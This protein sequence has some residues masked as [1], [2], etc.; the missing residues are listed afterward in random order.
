M[1]TEYGRGRGTYGD[2]GRYTFQAALYN[3]E[4][5]DQKLSNYALTWIFEKYGYDVEKHG[6]F[7]NKIGPRRAIKGYPNERIGKK[8]QWIALCEMLARVSDNYSMKNSDNIEVYQGSWAPYCRDIDPSI[9]IRKSIGRS[10]SKLSNYWWNKFK[11]FD[12][13]LQ[14][15]EWIASYEFLNDLSS[16][17]EVKDNDGNLWLKLQGY[18]E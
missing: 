10:S 3:W 18:P 16:L 17:I 15:V 5:D 7:D 4:L 14:G 12:W 1:T 9:L 2:F 11:C 13:N 8:Y 6:K